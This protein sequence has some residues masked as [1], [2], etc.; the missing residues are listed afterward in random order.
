M[1]IGEMKNSK[2]IKKEDAGEG[3]LVTIAG[4]EQQNVALDDQPPEMKWILHF[5]EFDKG[6]I[7]RASCRER[8]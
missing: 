7:G 8:G 5:H 1:R 4:M 6:K 3:K 2:F